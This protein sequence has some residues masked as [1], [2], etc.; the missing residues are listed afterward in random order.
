M[1]AVRFAADLLLALPVSVFQAEDGPDDGHYLLQLIIMRVKV[2]LLLSLRLS[3]PFFHLYFVCCF[4]FFANM[5]H[6]WL[7]HEPGITGCKDCKYVILPPIPRPVVSDCKADSGESVAP[8]MAT[9]GERV[10]ASSPLVPSF[11]LPVVL[12][13]QEAAQL[14]KQEINYSF[15]V[16]SRPFS[17]LSHPPVH[18]FADPII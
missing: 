6:M 8:F 10:S 2:C 7:R 14:L 15:K 4:F 11:G 18:P 12:L 5:R 13:S 16:R 9:T 1:Y 17:L 3:F